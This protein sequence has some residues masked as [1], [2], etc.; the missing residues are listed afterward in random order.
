MGLNNIDDNCYI[1]GATKEETKSLD[2]TNS[3]PNTT[4]SYHISGENVIFTLTCNSG[5]VFEN[6]PKIFFYT[7]D[8]NPSQPKFSVNES[9]NV[10]T[11]TCKNADTATSFEITGNTV[12]GG[13]GGEITYNVKNSLVNCEGDGNLPTEYPAG[14]ISITLKAVEG[15]EF[16]KDNPP[17]VYYLNSKGNPVLLQFNV[18]DDLTTASIVFTPDADDGTTLEFSGGAVQ[19]TVIGVNYGSINVYLVTLENLDAF[20][21][22]RFMKEVGDPETG[23]TF[24]YID[25]G[26]YVNRIKRIFCDIP[27]GADAVIQCGNYDTGIVVKTPAVE[28]VTVDFGNVTIPAHNSDLADYES[29]IQLFLPFK[30]FVTVPSDMAGKEVNLQYIINVITGDGV[31][32]LSSDGVPFIMES[33]S[34]IA[35]IIYRLGEDITVIGSDDWNEQE[36]YGKSAFV[37]V[38]WYESSNK[39][40][41]SGEYRK[42]KIGDLSGFNKLTDI[43]LISTP[44]M[45][46]DEQ[47]MI[48]NALENGVYL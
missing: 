18:S 35:N 16:K 33:V 15:T 42:A 14:E 23:Q 6:A 40:G 48:Y 8:G 47:E 19:K 44:E 1:L 25:L 46:A 12:Q 21:K 31:A 38:K 37:F 32:V 45:L 20:A 9:N 10:A 43:T 5:F 7:N 36:L 30:G 11:V 22:K 3:V 4:F 17:Q 26:Q 39:D 24:Q 28:R 41:V 13:G 34:P 29:E 2:V 27:N